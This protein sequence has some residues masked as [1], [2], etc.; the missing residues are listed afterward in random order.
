[1]LKRFR[2]RKFKGRSD[3]LELDLVLEHEG[4]TIRRRVKVP[5]N[6]TTP[7]ACRAV[8]AGRAPANHTPAVRW[9]R[10]YVANLQANH[11]RPAPKNPSR[12]PLFADF[13]ERFCKERAVQI[14][15]KPATR[16]NWETNLRCHLLPILG[17]MPIDQIGPSEVARLQ[18][19]P[20]LKASTINNISATLKTIL[21]WAVE[22]ELLD[23]APRV[24]KLKEIRTKRPEDMWWEE[25]ELAKLVQAAADR[26]VESLTF[27]LLG[28]DAGL[29]VGE[30]VSLRWED[31]D[32]RK[33]ALW[34]R[35]NVSNGVI[36]DTPKGSR[37][38]EIPLSP[39]LARAMQSH[40]HLAHECV[41]YRDRGNG[42]E[43]WSTDTAKTRLY[44]LCRA[45]GLKKSGTHRLRHSCGSRLGAL[46]YAQHEIMK[47]LG[48]AKSDTTLIYLHSRK[49]TQRAMADALG[50]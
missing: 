4:K 40:R 14:R 15:A 50:S 20:D 42:A 49:A 12:V 19:K 11:G 29:R 41:L 44:S 37:M 28:C 10:S 26:G 34:V 39:R 32:L 13:A 46:G 25:D 35:R 48:H 30:L 3:A 5:P 38:R 18:S 8:S 47:Y 9:G 31:V 23:K 24:R 6:H 22:L 27:V 16:K 21:R 33:C 2:F 1:M 45:A 17:S 36:V 43:P 7:A